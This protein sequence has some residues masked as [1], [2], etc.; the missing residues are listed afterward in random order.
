[1]DNK[2]IKEELKRV[3]MQ[4]ALTKDQKERERLIV[5]AST[6]HTNLARNTYNE[7]NKNNKRGR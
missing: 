7:M 6:I 3:R 5:L 1:M 4:I 2:E